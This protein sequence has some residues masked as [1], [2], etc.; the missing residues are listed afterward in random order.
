MEYGTDPDVF[1]TAAFQNFYLMG[2]A[3]ASFYLTA[4]LAMRRVLRKRR[5]QGSF[6]GYFDPIGGRRL[7]YATLSGLLVFGLA[8]L[9]VSVLWSLVHPQYHPAITKVIVRPHY[10]GHLAALG[11]ICVVLGPPTEE[12]F[13]RGLLLEWLQ[14]KLGRLPAASLTSMI[15]ALWHLRFLQ[16]PGIGGWIATALIAGM[17]FIC[18]QWA[19][20]THS[21]RAPIAVHATYNAA[22][23]LLF[24]P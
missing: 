21:L 1:V 15:F 8:L 19:Q 22:I 4:L 20:R 7:I 2:I 18:A 17:G 13:F 24:C 6:A 10:V 14:P 23:V 12:M 5:G 3:I 16:N 9:V 11:F